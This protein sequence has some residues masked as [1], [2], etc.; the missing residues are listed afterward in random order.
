MRWSTPRSPATA[1]TLL[2]VASLVF[3]SP[4]AYPRF[5]IAGVLLAEA[6]P[7]LRYCAQLADLLD[8]GVNRA[9]LSTGSEIYYLNG[10][11]FCADSAP[12]QYRCKCDLALA[13]KEKLDPWG[14]NIGMCSCCRTWV[15]FCLIM[16]C[17]FF[18][19]CISSSIYVLLLQGCW[20]CD[21]YV[22]PT[23]A[24]I[25]RRGPTATCPPSLPLPDY[26]FRGYTSTDFVNVTSPSS[27][28]RA[29]PPET[30]G[31]QHVPTEERNTFRVAVNE[32]SGSSRAQTASEESSFV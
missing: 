16:F 15:I 20:W 19:L 12:A 30:E 3:F 22:R 11:F 2:L 5:G 9:L 18:G 27:E 32:Y 13:C 29:A 25:P 8:Y 23:A 26:L 31:A 4:S 6:S 14:R 21:G 24:L 1:A 17:I 10:Y 7:K 28:E